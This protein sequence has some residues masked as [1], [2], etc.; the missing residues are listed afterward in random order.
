MTGHAGNLRAADKFY[1]LSST[2]ILAEAGICEINGMI[3]FQHHVFE[4]RPK[5]QSLEDVG[6]GF[7]C[8]IDCLCVTAALNIENALVTPAMFIIANQITLRVRREGCLIRSRQP[9]Q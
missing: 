3:F 6:L 9:E 7:W 4:N 5:P 2:R 8:K 1:G